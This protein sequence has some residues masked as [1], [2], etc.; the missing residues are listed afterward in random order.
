MIAIDDSRC[1]GCGECVGVC[2]N[3]AITL[4]AGKASVDETV[5]EE[6]EICLSVCPHNAI[7]SVE[8]V[9]PVLTEESSSNLETTPT[10]S[11]PDRGEYT[12]PIRD[13][14]ALPALTSVLLSTGREVIPRLTSMAMDLLDQR[15]RP[16]DSDS[17]VKNAQPRQQLSAQETRGRR[18]RQRRRRQG[19]R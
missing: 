16:A 19:K 18:R 5:C 8:A 14:E 12:P 15:I 17:Q 6:C 10:G 4:V 11:V 1:T 7:I 9:G 2:P 3:G 13:G